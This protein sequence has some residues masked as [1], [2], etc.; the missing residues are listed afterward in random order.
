MRNAKNSEDNERRKDITIIYIS[1]VV[2][3]DCLLR[4]LAVIDLSYGHLFRDIRDNMKAQAKDFPPS[5]QN[6][7]REEKK[8]SRRNLLLQASNPMR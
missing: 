4:K 6:M 7:Y 8:N 2:S 5:E 1:S 3:A